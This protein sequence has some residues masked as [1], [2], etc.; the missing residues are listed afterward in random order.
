MFKYDIARPQISGLASAFALLLS[1]SSGWAE[2]APVEEGLA[3]GAGA[4]AKLACSGVFVAG[5]S[6]GQI[7]SD[8]NRLLP[9]YTEGFEYS[10]DEK[11][12][13][14]TVRKPQIERTALYRPGL[15]CTLLV[16]TDSEAL[17]KQ[18]KG[19]KSIKM[20][21]RRAPWPA[22]DEVDLGTLPTDVDA[23]KL[24]KAL[25]DI[26]ADDIP[27]HEIDTRAIIVVHDGRII[28]ERYADGFSQDT[29]FLGWSAS[30]SVTSALVGALVSE[31][32][33]SLDERAPI[34]AWDRADDPRH[35][36]TLRNLLNMSSG[37]AFTEVRYLPGEDSTIMLFERGDMAGY[38]A[39]L[40]MEAK[41]DEV[42]KYSS[43]TTNMLARIAFDAAGG[44]LAA[45]EKFARE[46]F[47]LPAG[48]TSAV[49]ERDASG[50]MV[51]SSS[52]YATARDWA[53]FGLLHLNRGVINGNEVLSPEWVDFIHTPAP[54]NDE[55]GGQFWRNGV[56][57]KEKGQRWFP[58]LPADAYFALGHN[59]QVVG[60]I[61]SRD[62]VIVRLG[63]A[64]GG[65]KFDINRH[66]AAI[67]SA[68]GE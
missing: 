62:V 4:A 68:I 1:A 16:D 39:S 25:D 10:V 45:S 9:P 66:Y 28:A 33:L 7:E 54:T 44:T 64:S 12:K 21:K 11:H 61:P 41:P 3:M 42:F 29:R 5:Y 53:R 6:L 30:K 47:F 32:E 34:A 58:D 56:A 31:G 18:A 38:A 51:G 59:T 55:Y 17:K 37:L 26:F 8:I 19:V 35:E 60:I 49:F 46:Q 15:G 13:T 2:D 24:A 23:T 36:I 63:W 57:D 67:L 43:G 65:G 48:M 20:K 52:F 22:G 14:A 27:D 50:A 40:P